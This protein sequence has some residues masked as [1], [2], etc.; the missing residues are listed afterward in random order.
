M[1]RHTPGQGDRAQDWT[2]GGCKPQTDRR[3]QRQGRSLS[4]A[5]LVQRVEL[6]EESL[7]EADSLYLPDL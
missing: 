2:R 7:G 6:P 4:A 3:G 1:S 5:L